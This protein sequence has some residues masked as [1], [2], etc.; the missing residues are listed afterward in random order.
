MEKL[1]DA[2]ELSRLLDV[3]LTWVWAAAREDRIPCIRVG[4][5][6]RFNPEEVL[7]FLRSMGAGAG[8]GN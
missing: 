4:R 8:H 7:E 3:P 1:I 5:Y 6:Q 2:K